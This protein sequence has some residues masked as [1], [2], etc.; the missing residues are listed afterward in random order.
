MILAHNIHTS[1]LRWIVVSNIY[2]LNKCL[3]VCLQIAYTLH[4]LSLQTIVS[5]L[6][7]VP[8]LDRQTQL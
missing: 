6:D 2:F 7:P 4:L 1:S 8:S 3:V 5:D